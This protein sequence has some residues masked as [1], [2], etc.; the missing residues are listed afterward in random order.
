MDAECIRQGRQAVLR[1]GPTEAHSTAP[2]ADEGGNTAWSE[3]FTAKIK[4]EC[5]GLCVL[6]CK[7]CKADRSPANPSETN[8]RHKCTTAAVAAVTAAGGSSSKGEGSN[9]KKHAREE[10]EVEEVD[11]VGQRFRG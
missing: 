2:D 5:G 6:E 1:A 11:C 8:R 7:R 4:P 9:S 10:Q 3:R